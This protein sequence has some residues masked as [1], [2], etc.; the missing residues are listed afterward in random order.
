MCSKQSL[1]S[2]LVLLAALGFAGN[3]LAE[4]PSP[5]GDW[6]FTPLWDQDEADAP[7]TMTFNADGTGSTTRGDT[8]TWSVSGNSITINTQNPATGDPAT[9]TYMGNFVQSG[10][11]M[12][13][14]V[15]ATDGGFSTPNDSG[16]WMAVR[17]GVPIVWVST[18]KFPVASEGSP[19]TTASFAINLD[20][21]RTND[22]VVSYS[23][24]GT[25]IPGTDYVALSGTVTIPAG[26]LSAFVTV[27]PQ[28]TR[29][30][31]QRTVRIDLLSDPAYVVS[32]EDNATIRI[33]GGPVVANISAT[34]ADANE[35]MPPKNGVFTVSLNVA[36]ANPITV[37]YTFDRGTAVPGTDYTTLSG[38]VVIPAGNTDATITVVPDN[39]VFDGIRTVIV[40]LA[41]DANNPPAYVLLPALS[42]DTVNIAP[43][44]VKASIAASTPRAQ[45]GSPAVNGQFTVF[46]SAAPASALTINYTVLATSTAVAGT[47]YSALS[48]TV[49]IPAG[50]TSATIDVIPDNTV[51]SGTRSVNVM[52]Q[53]GTGY[54][55]IPANTATVLIA[56]ARANATIVAT[57]PQAREGNP[58]S[59][60]EFTVYLD[61]ASGSDLTINLAVDAGS[62]A[63]SGTDYVALPPTVTIPMGQTQ[64]SVVVTPMNSIFDGTRAIIVNLQPGTGYVVGDPGTDTVYLSSLGYQAGVIAN[65]AIGLEGNRVG[66]SPVNGQFTVQLNAASTNDLQIDYIVDPASTGRAGVDYTPLSGTVTVPAFSTS[67]TI[68]VVPDRSFF[69]K[70]RNVTI[71]LQDGI[72]YTVGGPSSATVTLSSPWIPLPTI[73][74][75]PDHLE[76]TAVVGVNPLGQQFDVVNIGSGLFDYDVNFVSD[77]NWLTANP[78]KGNTAGITSTV[79]TSYNTA[80]LAVGD[81]HGTVRI[82]SQIAINSPQ[83]LPV[84]LHVIPSTPWV[85]LSPNTLNQRALAGTRAASQTFVVRNSGTGTL[86]F[87]LRNNARWVQLSPTSGSLASTATQTITVN[88]DTSTLA[89][90]LHAATVSVAAPR[91][92]SQDVTLILKVA[93]GAVIVAPL[94]TSA[95]TASG[96]ENQAFSYQITAS[97]TA[98]F[99]FGATPLPPGLTL[100]NDTISG[101]PTQGGIFSVSISAS[102]SAGSDTQTL[103]LTIIDPNAPPPVFES[104]PTATPDPANTG[105][106]VTFSASAADAH[107]NSLQYSWDFGDGTTALGQQVTHVYAAPGLFHVKVSASNGTLTTNS[108]TDVV[109]NAAGSSPPTLTI[110]KVQI[111]FNFMKPGNDSI[112]LSGTVTLTA[113][114]SPGQTITVAIADYQLQVTISASG[115]FTLPK[116]ATFKVGGKGPTFKFTLGQSHISLFHQLAPL[117]FTNAN[118]SKPQSIAMLVVLEVGTTGATATPVVSYTAKKGKLG[119]AKK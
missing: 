37:F 118:I 110:N 52:L 71:V 87:T 78:L 50:A 26:Q 36:P 92:P 90:G 100:S 3:A 33:I 51:Y 97:G 29:F 13:G 11:G 75:Q 102:N 112:A 7:Y 32:S 17:E 107:G 77:G 81:H 22:T 109:V 70:T 72:G 21:A 12:Q 30:D 76:V 106:T 18:G 104:P 40:D 99:T 23:V 84:L 9:A 80:A 111:K 56:G 10:A 79:F 53:S 34:Q 20:V 8:L 115:K 4:S 28:N 57:A 114:P 64:A 113:I 27:T 93:P 62:S 15:V 24:S 55:L 65:D 39:T 38:S 74:L 95:L 83:D 25:A 108:E 42:T 35:G 58:P 119:I 91:V 41:I 61:R 88:Y 46:V 103:Q 82:S 1:Y 48:G 117:G 6:D 43:A 60:G 66:L 94:I 116:G 5:V 49:T 44:G 47:D 96:T 54:S 31:D 86:N 85:G 59:E 2:G 98:P 14:T 67:A 105:D 101:T 63:I 45:E 68:D 89:P 16:R 19:P 69:F 73:G